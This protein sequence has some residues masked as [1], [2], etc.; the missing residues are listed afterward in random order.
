MEL[1]FQLADLSVQ[2][3]LF[4]RDVLAFAFQFSQFDDFGQVSF[5][6]PFFLSD[7]VSQS[8][9]EGLPPGLELLR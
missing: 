9:V 2:G 1:S 4:L 3:V 7:Q 5:Q 6:Q 8:L